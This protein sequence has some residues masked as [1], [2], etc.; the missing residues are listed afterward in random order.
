M[1]SGAIYSHPLLGRVAPVATPIRMGGSTGRIGEYGFTRK[2]TD[3]SLRHHDG[4]DLLAPVGWPIFATH[5]GKVTFADEARGY[6]LLIKIVRITNDRPVIGTRY[7]HLSHI[8]CKRY[9]HVIAGQLIGNVG[10][11]GNADD[12]PP[13]LHFEFREREGR[14]WS[15]VDPVLF[16]HPF[17]SPRDE[18][19]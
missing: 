13:H 1:S 5:D 6:G 9:E 14:L 19:A 15:L 18:H 7:A 11:S 3:G 4:V 12:T 10:Q 16:I 8:R 17:D 2:R